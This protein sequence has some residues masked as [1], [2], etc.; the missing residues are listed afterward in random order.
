MKKL[1]LVLFVIIAASC[2]DDKAPDVCGVNDPVTELQWLQDKI[3]E[4][5]NSE[6]S[7]KYFYVA[8]ADY[9]GSVV[10]YVNNCCPMCS[11]VLIYYDCSGNQVESVD[12]SEIKNSKRIWTP[13]GLEC[14]FYD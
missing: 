13:E 4:I 14:V 8:Q 12:T 6:F 2:K 9:K 7:S 11:T 5:K 1:L 3:A 10:F